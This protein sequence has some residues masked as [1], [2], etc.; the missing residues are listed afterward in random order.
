[1]NFVKVLSMKESSANA[2]GIPGSP[3]PQGTSPWNNAVYASR[4]FFVYESDFPADTTLAPGGVLNESFNIAGDSDFFWTKFAIASLEESGAA[5]GIEDVPAVSMLLTNTTTGRQYST[6]AVALANMAGT[7]KLPF[8]LPQ[9]TM[10][11]R[12][13][14]IQIQLQNISADITYSNVFLSFLGIKAFPQAGQ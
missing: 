13:S 10:W 5:A 3:M 14:T 1:M 12:K 9:I 4:N 7:G 6:S 8:I 2:S 11:Q